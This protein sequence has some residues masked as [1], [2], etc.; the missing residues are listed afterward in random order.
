MKKHNFKLKTKE[1][2]KV[3][4]NKLYFYL[5]FKYY[6]IFEKSKLM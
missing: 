1:K 2:K 3:R 5:I 6:N 4:E